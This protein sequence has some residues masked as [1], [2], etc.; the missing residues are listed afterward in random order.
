MVNLKDYISRGFLGERAYF[1][2]SVP[3]NSMQQMF[4]RL[5]KFPEPDES[6]IVIFPSDEN[7]RNEK[8]ES[9]SVPLRQHL[10]DLLIDNQ[11]SG[12]QEATPAA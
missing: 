11:S 8:P 4:Y 7:G 3:L 9:V 2:S 1:R 5:K 6:I 10:D 12:R